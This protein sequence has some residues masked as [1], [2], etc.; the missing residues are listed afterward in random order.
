MKMTM[1][2]EKTKL[3]THLTYDRLKNTVNKAHPHSKNS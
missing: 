1:T 2:L 3:Y